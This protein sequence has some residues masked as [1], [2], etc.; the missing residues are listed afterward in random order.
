VV[1]GRGL[2]VV[3]CGWLWLVVVVVGCGWLWLV[4]EGR[5]SRWSYQ[6]EHDEAACESSDE[7]SN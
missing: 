5:V 1:V 3:G 4:V 2:V 7:S 6:R